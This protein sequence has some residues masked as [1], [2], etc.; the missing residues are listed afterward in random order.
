MKSVPRHA[1]GTD[2]STHS[3]GILFDLPHVTDMARCKLAEAS[4]AQRCDFV[5]GGF[6]NEVPSGGDV[7]LIKKVIHDWDNE[8]ATDILG[9]CRTAAQ[10]DGRCCFWRSSCPPGMNLHSPR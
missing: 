1:A 5:A 10:P 2:G 4:L 9:R 7:Y 8:R 3:R 6:F